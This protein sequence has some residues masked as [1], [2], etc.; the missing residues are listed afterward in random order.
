MRTIADEILTNS[1]YYTGAQYLQ[2]IID[3]VYQSDVNMFFTYNQFL[4]NLTTDVTSGPDPIPGLTNLMN[5]RTA[6]LYSTPEFQ[7]VPPTLSNIQ[8]SDTLPLI[9]SSIYITANVTNATAVF[10]GLRNSV[11][12]KFVRM[13]MYDNGL[14]GDGGAGDGVYGVTLTVTSA[15]IQYYIYAENINAGIFSPQRA[16]H[17]WYTLNSNY[18]TLTTGEVVIN[19]LSAVNNSIQTNGMGNYGDWIELYNTTADTVLLDYLYL[20]DDF[21]NPAKWQFPE[22]TKILPNGY[23]IIW[24]DNDIFTGE[25]HSGFKLS[26]SGEG[27]LL[28]YSNGSII[29]SITFPSQTGDI[30][31]GRYPNGVG[32]FVF[33]PP[34]FN[35]VNLLTG[36][37]EQSGRTDDYL[38]RNFVK[39]RSLHDLQFFRA[40]CKG[41]KKYFGAD[42]YFVP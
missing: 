36:F 22:D 3:T 1:Y 27:L 25:L 40:D 5:A 37:E 20:S 19:E 18:T 7:Q 10:C 29:D 23:L 30:T 42:S 11:M 9:N 4:S 17:E 13:Q 15:E 39:R 14:N 41:N 21:T 28:S 16:E 34:T 38:H 12:N 33:M 32:T 31:Y 6:F 26:G 24:A 35:A 8:P 2:N